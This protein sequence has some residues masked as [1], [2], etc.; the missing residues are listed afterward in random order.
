MNFDIYMAYPLTFNDA[1]KL[2]IPG[3][4]GNVLEWYDFSLYGYFAPIISKLFFPETNQSL[5]LLLTFGVFAIGFLMRPLGAMFFGYFGDRLGRKRILAITI[6]LMAIP[7]V[8]IGLLP[9][10]Q[11]IGIWAGILMLICRLVQGFAVGGSYT[12][13]MVYVIEHAPPQHRGLFGSCVIFS[14]DIGFMLASAVGAGTSALL[15]GTAYEYL[16]WRIPFLF[17]F[18]VALI[19]LYLRSRMP[20]TP[21]FLQIQTTRQV[22]TNPLGHAFKNHYGKLI[23]AAAL[24]FLSAI[25]FYTIFVYLSSYLALYVHIPLAQT[26]E[27]NTIAMAIVIC[28][29]PFIGYLSDKIGRKPFFYLSAFGFIFLSYPLFSLIL[30]GSI[31][32]VLIAQVIFGI[33]ILS[34]DAIV[35][36]ALVEMMPTNIRYTAMALPYS[37]A[38]GVFGGTAPLVA[39][40]LIQYTHLIKAPIIYLMFGGLFMLLVLQFI[41]ET[42]R[43]KFVSSAEKFEPIQTISTN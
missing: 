15:A 29:I 27:L 19:G 16:N 40:Y 25:G 3:V 36:T 30:T 1:K 33:L 32:G 41:G 13:S 21:D 37:I 17:G 22:L 20:E 8:L 23:K 39:T 35:P 6:I 18:V 10:Y 9:T 26:L 5:S 34:S 11:Y 31:V 12:G 28:A 4:I 42:R 2:I 14:G 38:T 7:T 24:T 43:S